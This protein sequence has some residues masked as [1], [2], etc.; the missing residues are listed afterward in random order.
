YLQSRPALDAASRRLLHSYTKLKTQP[1]GLL[2]N[3]ILAFR[4]YRTV[5]VELGG[6]EPIAASSS[7]S[8]TPS[9]SGADST[10]AFQISDSSLPSY[11]YLGVDEASQFTQCLDVLEN[12]LSRPPQPHFK[13]GTLA[14]L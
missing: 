4:V 10:I 14:A 9:K 3:S 12:K 7:Q 11:E 5:E 8:S 2:F 13:F 6:Q 1:S